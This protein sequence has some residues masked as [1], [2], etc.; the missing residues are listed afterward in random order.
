MTRRIIY[1]RML[2]KEGWGYWKDWTEVI[3]ILVSV[4]R[5]VCP[6]HLFVTLLCA[7]NE[8]VWVSQRPGGEANTALTFDVRGSGRV[9]PV[10]FTCIEESSSS[11]MTG[12]SDEGS[13]KDRQLECQLPGGGFKPGIRRADRGHR[14]NYNTY[15]FVWNGSLK[16]KLL[17]PWR[18]RQL[19]GFGRSEVVFC[20]H[21]NEQ[22]RILISQGGGVRGWPS[23]GL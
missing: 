12:A 17:I 1:S 16:Y 23:S 5:A 10:T 8:V 18:E 4:M 22:S 20:E 15:Q 19:K 7:K 13:V 2:Q 3:A 14:F 6:A 21:G 9:S 11:S